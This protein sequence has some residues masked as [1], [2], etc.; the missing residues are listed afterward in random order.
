MPEI[1][2]I[3]LYCNHKWSYQSYYTPQDPK[4]RCIKC[5]E[6]KMIKAKV[7]NEN[8]LNNNIFGYEEDEPDESPEDIDQR[9]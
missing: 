8:E 3:C 2:L 1:R 9:D 5:S 6:T 4:T 7:V